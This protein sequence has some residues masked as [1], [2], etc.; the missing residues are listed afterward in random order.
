[1]IYLKISLGYFRFILQHTSLCSPLV[2]NHSVYTNVDGGD[3]R[4]LKE[5]RAVRL[6]VAWVE[7]NT[8]VGREG[9]SSSTLSLY[10]LALVQ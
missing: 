4:Y 3:F 7:T 10:I 5:L 6:G 9:E 2:F 8:T 1:M